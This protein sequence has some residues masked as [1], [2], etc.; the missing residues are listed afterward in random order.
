LAHKP[1]FR[2]LTEDLLRRSMRRF[3]AHLRYG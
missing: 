1:F 3:D 2:R